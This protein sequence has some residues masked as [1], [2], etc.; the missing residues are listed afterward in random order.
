MTV[1]TDLRC[2]VPESELVL[3]PAPARPCDLDLVSSVLLAGAPRLALWAA[4]LI[5]AADGGGGGLSRAA[6]SPL[7]MAG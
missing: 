5:A 1:L 7:Y 6:T 3:K 2:S 4:C